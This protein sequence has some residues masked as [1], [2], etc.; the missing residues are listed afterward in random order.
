M[1]GVSENLADL[2]KRTPWSYRSGGRNEL[3]QILEVP[4]ETWLRSRVADGY[5]DDTIRDL[6]RDA[7]GV[8]VAS[9]TVRHWRRDIGYRRRKRYVK[10]AK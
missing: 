5:T 4:L 8:T 3:S 10:E 1:D 7:T 6:L 2:R 9:D